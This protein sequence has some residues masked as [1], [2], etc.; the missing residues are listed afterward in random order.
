MVIMM[1]IMK[2][3]CFAAGGW[4]GSQAEAGSA[5]EKVNLMTMMMNLLGEPSKMIFVNLLWIPKAFLVLKMGYVLKQTERNT[6]TVVYVLK[7]VDLKICWP[8]KFVTVVARNGNSLQMI[9]FNVSHNVSG[10]SFL[11]TLYKFSHELVSSHFEPCFDLSPSSI[12][13]FFHPVVA[14]L[15]K[16]NVCVL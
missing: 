15:Q 5:S 7:H 9:C 3:C 16:K 1:I 13:Q 2:G 4:E 12:W 6:F 8:E 14:N 11:S 10:T